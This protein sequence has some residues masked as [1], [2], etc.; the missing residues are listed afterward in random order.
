MVDGG[1]HIVE[2]TWAQVS[3][4]MNLV[5]TMFINYNQVSIMHHLIL[6]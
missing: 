1:D 5:S 4:M 2:A 6:C 3:G